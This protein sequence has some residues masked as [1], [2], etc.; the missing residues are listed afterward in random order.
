MKHQTVNKIT[1]FTIPC[2]DSLTRGSFQLKIHIASAILNLSSINGKIGHIVFF[3]V[4]VLNMLS[5]IFCYSE[6]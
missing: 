2:E 5:C 6:S 4:M 3:A 1:A